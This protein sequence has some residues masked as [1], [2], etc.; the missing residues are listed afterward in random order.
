MDFLTHE[1]TNYI[2]KINGL[3]ISDEDRKIMGVMYSAIQDLERI[4]DHAENITDCVKTMIDGKIVFSEDALGE[5]KHLDS[6]VISLLDSGFE[7][8]NTQNPDPVLAEE[9]VA[10][11]DE[12]DDYVDAYK[13]NHIKRMNEGLCSAENGTVFL[14]MLTVL[15]R[16]GD[17]ANNVAFSIP[18]KKLRAVV[19]QE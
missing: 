1:I 18:S 17:H 12:L 16:V 3:D 19:N 7:M 2:V 8:F 10:T 14:E 11:E 5:L 15:E 6:L 4:G 13:V 9:V